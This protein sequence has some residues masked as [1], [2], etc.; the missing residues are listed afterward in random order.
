MPRRCLEIRRALISSLFIGLLLFDVGLLAGLAIILALLIVC[1]LH[2]CLFLSV[3]LLVLHAFLAV[4][5]VVRLVIVIHDLLRLDAH[6]V[7]VVPFFAPVAADHVGFVRGLADAV[8]LPVLLLL[9]GLLIC[10][11]P[12]SV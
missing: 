5:A 9:V 7:E 4:R 1:V 8:Y 6:A 3:F 2:L 12:R 10:C 11:R